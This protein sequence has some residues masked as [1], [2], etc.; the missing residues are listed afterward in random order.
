[1]CILIGR[2]V[3]G[4]SILLR[5]SCK[6]GRGRRREEIEL[7]SGELGSGGPR[8]DVMTAFEYGVY[9]FRIGFILFYSFRWKHEIPHIA[10]IVEIHIS[11]RETLGIAPGSNSRTSKSL[12]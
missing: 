4:R 12:L 7:N 1:M 6:G 9:S 5:R 10:Q 11:N 8:N 2:L 3:I